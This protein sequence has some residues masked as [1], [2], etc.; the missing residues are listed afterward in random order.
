[1]PD[2]ADDRGRRGGV[3]VRALRHRLE[4]RDL[5]TV[6]GAVPYAPRHHDVDVP[7]MRLPARATDP[8]SP[9]PRPSGP[10][11]GS[12]S[13]RALIGATAPPRLDRRRGDRRRGDRGRPAHAGWLDDP[14]GEPDTRCDPSALPPPP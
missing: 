14:P 8:G 7:P 11:A 1:M 10:G 4:L 9:G 6:R 3:H 2:P 5:R 12:P 13:P